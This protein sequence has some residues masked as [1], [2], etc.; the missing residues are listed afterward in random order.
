MSGLRKAFG[1]G[2]R[3]A[4]PRPP[5]D[6]SQILETLPIA[7]AVLDEHDMFAA[8]NYAAEEFFGASKA[9]LLHTPLSDILPADHPIFL[10]LERTR[11][12]GVSIAEHNLTIE[13]PRLTR[14]GCSVHAAP[15]LEKPGYVALTLQDESA[16]LALDQQMSARNAARSITGMAAILAHEVKNPLSGIRGAAQLLEMS[17]PPSDRELAVLIRDEADRIRAMVERMETF[18]EKKLERQSVNIHRVLEHVRKLSGSGFAT[19]I[20]FIESYDPS[21]P[22]VLGNR[23]Q[24]IQ[25]LLNLIKNAAEAIAG[26]DRQDGEIHLTTGFQ[27]G[28]RLSASAGRSRPNLPI[29]V[30]V[31][32]NGPG[33]PEDIRR[34]LFEPFVSTKAAGSGLG[35][36]LVAKIV[37]DHGGLIDVDSR[38]GRTE[39]RIHLPVYEDPNEST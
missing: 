13:G 3:G 31:R 6:P 11:G 20:K 22:H 39:F 26:A 19:R 9:L 1:L 2:K 33:I 28:V 8:L 24:L 21:L 25:V 35:L 5:L 30:S 15:M 16:A 37:A 14:R 38:P 12:A 7:V 18:G 29:F 23:D 10:M 36:A 4:Q 32:D 34:H 17:A 27:H